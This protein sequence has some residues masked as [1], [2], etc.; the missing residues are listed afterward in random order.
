VIGL[1]A[2][3]DCS[4]SSVIDTKWN[5]NTTGVIDDSTGVPPLDINTLP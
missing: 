4:G 2:N 3:G 1:L 5:G